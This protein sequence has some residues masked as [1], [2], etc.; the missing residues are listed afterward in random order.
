VN[1]NDGNMVVTK[2]NGVQ[3]ATILL[4]PAGAGVL[5]GLTDV[6]EQGV[7]FVDDGTNTLDLFHEFHD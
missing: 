2:P 5:F 1:G 4:D 7:C 3:S 6:P